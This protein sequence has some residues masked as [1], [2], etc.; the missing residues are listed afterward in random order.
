MARADPKT[1]YIN[2]GTAKWT[3]EVGLSPFRALGFRVPIWRCVVFAKF[4][5][6]NTSTNLSFILCLT[7][8]F[9][10]TG[11]STFLRQNALIAILAQAGSFVPAQSATIGKIETVHWKWWTHLCAQV[12]APPFIWK[13]LIDSWSWLS[14]KRFFF[15]KDRSWEWCFRWHRRLEKKQCKFRQQGTIWHSY[16]RYRCS[17]IE[18]DEIRGSKA[19]KLG[20][21]EKNTARVQFISCFFVCLFLCLFLFFQ[22]IAQ[23]TRKT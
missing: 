9:H 17:T 6:Q 16:Y 4:A 5:T 22:S 1:N 8:T 18:V 10:L 11:K 12:N 23:A 15:S 14:I 2:G 7:R 21:W 13:N 3:L 19:I 20:P